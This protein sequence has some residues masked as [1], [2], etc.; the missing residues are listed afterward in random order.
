MPLM[1]AL[2]ENHLT[3]D[4]S[5]YMAVV[6]DLQSKTQEDVINLMISRG[7]TVT[8]AE[9]L[10]VF[11]EYALALE[12]LV[13]D[14]YAVN[15][16]LFNLSPSIKGV[17]YSDTE[18]FNP[19]THTVRLNIS[20]GTRLRQMASGISLSRVQG[21][22]PQPDPLYLEDLGSGTRNE[23][24]TSGNIAQLIGS[25]LKFEASDQQQGIFI[26]AADG[27]ET[28]VTTVSNNKP[29]RLDFLVPPLTAGTYRIEVRALIHHSM[30]LRKGTLP[31]ELAVL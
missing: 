11:E 27:A 1:Y 14:G 26:L 21:A 19:A 10:S 17:F 9:A 16:P 6:Q 30:N 31:V 5:D 12:Q 4:P 3:A 20:P 13:T 2:F 8:K 7:S 29:S 22:S 24:L 18:P 28:R 15:T 23:T 25:R